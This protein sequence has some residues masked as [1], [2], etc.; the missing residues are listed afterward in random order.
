M[1]DLDAS[2]TWALENGL[3]DPQRIGMTGFCWGGRI[4]WLYASQNNELRAGV[5][6]YGRLD[7][8]VTQNQPKHPINVADDL[9]CPVL[10][11]YGGQDHLI[12]NDLVEKMNLKLRKNDKNSMI[13]SYP[14][15]G[16]GFFADY[17]SSYNHKDAESGWNE[18]QAWFRKF[19]ILE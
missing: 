14:Q 9:N 12:P 4:V 5:A 16:H 11:L 17:R 2:V 13:I 15:S 3:A 18:L 7:N 10:G 8:Q 19:E 1:Q 6:W